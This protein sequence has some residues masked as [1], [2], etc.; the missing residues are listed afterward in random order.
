VRSL[1]L[2]GAFKRDLKRIT[3]RQYAIVKLD[4]VVDALS[5]GEPLPQ[6]C[7]PHPLKGEW[8]GY[9]ECH[10]SPDWLLIYQIQPD[11]LLLARTG[12]HAD[13]FDE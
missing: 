9:H 2:S 7:R 4:Q 11:E 10:I 1:R 3:R 6:V 5:T 13:L 8:K 12:T